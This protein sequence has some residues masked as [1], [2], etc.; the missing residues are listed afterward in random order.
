M[1][2]PKPT[3]NSSPKTTKACQMTH[4]MRHLR[5]VITLV[6]VCGLSLIST[7]AS[8]SPKREF[9]GAWVQIINGQFQGL[10]TEATQ[11]R[12]LDQL[13]AMQ[14]CGINTVMFQVRGEA[15]AMYPSPYE[16]WSRFLTG[17]QGQAPSPYWDPL[18]WM[19]N[20]CHKRQMELHA[21]INPYRAKTKGT[22]ELASTHPY[23]QWPERFFQYDDLVLFDPALQE[24][25]DYI[26]RVVEDI[27]TRYD[28]DGLHIDDYFYPYPVAGQPIPDDAS[29]KIYNN[30]ITNRADWRRYNVNLFIQ[31]LFLTIRQAKPWVKFG[32]SPFGI[33]HNK[34]NGGNIPGSDTA[35]LQNYDDLYADVLYWIHQGWVDYVVPQIYWEIGH[36]TADYDRLVRWWDRY[37]SE[38]PLVIGQDIDRTVKH[39]DFAL[40]LGLQRSMRHVSGSC[41]W[42]SAALASN[43]GNYAEALRYNYHQRPALQPLMPFIDSR[44]PGKPTKLRPVWTA[45]G[46]ILFWTAPKAK[47][48]MDRAR[49][50]VVYAFPK[51]EAVDLNNTDRIVTITTDTHYQLP[52]EHGMRKY[53]YIVTALDRLQNESKPAKRTVKL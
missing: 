6:A 4:L 5:A 12:L 32:V 52:F 41:M 45:S 16:P 11:R 15:D 33:Y 14:R 36:P 27:V 22:R 34:K 13:N 43:T 29:Y 39:G 50:Y 1:H 8:T 2:T 7:Q 23:V 44:E 51:G 26:C 48:E 20:E 19:I 38:R 30:G 18:E 47:T 31:Q 10:G 42:Y 28:I 9:R 35:G 40:K 25:R 53:T 17:R 24:N 3:S 46:Y 37:A 21:W 49:Q